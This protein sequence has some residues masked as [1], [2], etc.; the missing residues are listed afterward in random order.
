[1]LMLVTLCFVLWGAV[2]AVWAGLLIARL[3]VR[4]LGLI[5]E[6]VRGDVPCPGGDAAADRVWPSV[7]VVIP[8]RNEGAI[9]AECLDRVLA[10]DYPALSVLVADDRSEDDT[11]AIAGRYAAQD[12][13]VRVLPI[14]EMPSGWLG[15]TNALYQAARHVAADWILFTDADCVLD[16]WAVRTAVAE[17][18]RRGVAFLSVWPRQVPGGFWERLLIPLCAGAL[19]MWFGSTQVNSPRSRMAFANGQF[20]LVRRDAYER[21][22]GHKP[23]ANCLIEDIPLA[24]H[25][26]RSG[27]CCWAGSGRDIVA[28]RMYTSYKGIRDG[29]ARIYVGAYRSGV[30]LAL[31]IAWL[32]LGSLWPYVTLAGLAVAWL[33][34]AGETV[35][36]EASEWMRWGGIMTGVHLAL[37]YAVSWG[38]WGLGYADRRYLWLY[39]VSAVLVTGILC[40]AWWWLVVRRSI[41][42]RGRRYRI[43]G[44]A[45]LLTVPTAPVLAPAGP[46]C[47]P[48]RT[49]SEPTEPEPSS[50]PT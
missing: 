33:F 34:T 39:P 7:C 20:I 6:P 45:R 27:V 37:L 31:C 48:H 29:W 32:V 3:L 11:A 47:T 30:K 21:F 44:E 22:G 36:P 40:R 17:A 5:I 16:P 12:A 49:E 41:P 23:V 19:A 28:V 15:K 14:T 50:A 25:A 9:L 46:A 42:W 8:A 38:F 1:M 2:L 24:E 26:K 43:N 4:P 18:R 13:R 10:Q 35:A